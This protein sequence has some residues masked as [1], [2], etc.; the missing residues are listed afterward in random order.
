MSAIPFCA[1][2]LSFAWRWL[3]FMF[4]GPERLRHARC[5]TAFALIYI[6]TPAAFSSLEWLIVLAFLR[7][8]MGLFWRLCFCIINHFPALLGLGRHSAYRWPTWLV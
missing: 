5:S 3:V 8:P 7:G 4:G 2:H 6:D 1:E